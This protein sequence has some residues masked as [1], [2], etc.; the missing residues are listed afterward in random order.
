MHLGSF[1][2]VAVVK[3]CTQLSTVDCKRNNMVF[4]GVKLLQALKNL[5][6]LGQP[7]FHALNNNHIWF[8][9]PDLAMCFAASGAYLINLL[10]MRVLQCSP[11]ALA[12]PE[13]FLHACYGM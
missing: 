10:Q 5:T 12:A 3:P 9:N 8:H 1:L 7:G 2:P 6:A 13:D 4:R 11:L